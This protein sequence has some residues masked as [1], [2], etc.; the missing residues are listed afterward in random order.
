[1]AFLRQPTW[2]Q[3]DLAREVDVGV[4]ALK[5]RLNEMT[6]AGVNLQREEET[7][8]E[9]Y[10]SVPKGWF[11]GGVF[12]AD[13]EERL[14]LYA[15]A[16]HP[17]GPTQDRIL[18][19]LARSRALDEATVERMRSVV[20]MPPSSNEEILHLLFE[21]ASSQRVVHVD[22]YSS[23]RGQLR[24]R[25]LSVHRVLPGARPRCLATCHET[26][27]LK[28]FRVDSMSNPRVDEATDFLTATAEE[29]GSVL[30]GTVDGFYEDGREQELS[31]LIRED[32][33]SWVRRNLPTGMRAEDGPEGLRVRV[34][35]AAVR[36][37]ARFVV[38]LG[39]AATPETPVL[40]E[41]V[42]QIAQEALEA[43]TRLQARAASEES[44]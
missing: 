19:A 4:D 16:N 6:L 42:R 27:A 23:K 5:K 40:A 34:T 15:I 3:P 31:F 30:R 22:H 9:I 28:W 36:S 37:V 13:Q 20:V 39:G 7:P 11:P 2:R 14:L 43:A 21:A 25:R 33:A 26:E 41:S 44:R 35:T 24:P 29:V 32:D 10:W 17:S 38:G 8:T 12:L 1:M 18:T